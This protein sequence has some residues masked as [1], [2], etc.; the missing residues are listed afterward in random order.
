MQESE[1]I[2]NAEPVIADIAV[3]GAARLGWVA[4]L[5][6]RQAR[7]EDTGVGAEAGV[8]ESVCTAAGCP[9]TMRSNRTSRTPS[10]A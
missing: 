8:V 6:S 5:E 2:E 9:T 4:Q 3:D 7:S 1:S 10:G